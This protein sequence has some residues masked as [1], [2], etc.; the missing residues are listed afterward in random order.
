[1]DFKYVKKD[2][3]CFDGSDGSIDIFVSNTKGKLFLNWINLPQKS[4]IN[5]NG[6]SIRNIPYGIY[7]VEIEDDIFFGKNKKTLDIELVQP[8][9]IKVDFIQVSVPK[10]PDDKGEIK[11]F[12]SGGKP[13]YKVLA[14]HRSVITQNVAI[15]SNID[16]NTT[17]NKIII[18]DKNNC[19]LEHEQSIVL[20]TKPIYINVTYKNLINKEEKSQLVK[21]HIKNGAPP[22][23]IGWFDSNNNMIAT[24]TDTLQ[25]ILPKGRYSL[26]VIDSNNCVSQKNFTIDGPSPISVT[27]TTKADYS[28][29]NFF[30]YSKILKIHNLILIPHSKD[31]PFKE[32]IPGNTLYII[33]KKTKKIKQSVVL[34][35]DNITIDGIDYYYFYIG[36]GIRVED[37]IAFAKKDYQLSYNDQTIPLS[38][39]MDN[40]KTA[41]LLIGCLVLDN[42]FDYAFNNKDIIQVNIDNKLYNGQLNQKTNKYNFY[43]ALNTNTLL[44]IDSAINKEIFYALNSVNGF[45]AAYV[46]SLT[47]KRNDQKG[48][49]HL[50]ISGGVGSSLGVL[51]SVDNGYRYKV[52]C[53]S[54]NNNYNQVFY[55][56]HLLD[57]KFLDCGLYSIRIEDM[58]GNSVDFVNNQPSTNNQFEITI[59]GSIEEEQNMIQQEMKKINPIDNNTSNTFPKFKRITRPAKN[60]ANILINIKPINSKPIIFGPDNFTTQLSSGYEILTNLNP[61]KYTIKIDEQTK[62]FFLVQN[63]TYYLNDMN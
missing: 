1:M 22:Y 35:S 47:T 9:K 29:N 14:G 42:N 7:R 13:P 5:N 63:D 10:C 44:L 23:K 53:N 39:I 60:K 46:R 51:N 52:Y 37:D 25:N 36:N 40:K 26:R 62:N 27:Y 21:A 43:D 38:L 24:N 61:G 45:K 34:N 49:I 18:T 11:V 31:S 48:S 54:I 4:I 3:S 30:A 57:I 50:K 55:T 41:K 2:P 15:F 8:K 12:I 59:L 33:H 6:L 19:V 58:V 20:Y 56:N 16:N 28:C 17:I 32:I